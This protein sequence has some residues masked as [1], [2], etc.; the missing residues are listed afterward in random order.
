M[1][2]DKQLHGRITEFDIQRFTTLLK[3][4]ERRRE[5]DKLEEP[6]EEY[7]CNSCAENALL[8]Y[9][10]CKKLDWRACKKYVKAEEPIPDSAMFKEASQVTLATENIHLVK[11]VEALKKMIDEL[12]HQNELIKEANRRRQN[13]YSS[14]LTE[15]EGLEEVNKKLQEEVK[16]AEK[17]KLTAGNRATF[18][19]LEEHYVNVMN[20]L[21]TLESKINHL[22][23]VFYD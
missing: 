1:G 20:R 21:N 9:G 22:R 16:H 19:M 7:K 5:Q 2:K 17:G 18:N 14:L 10:A 8:P 3:E 23:V 6:K 15:C 13:A 11:E 12:R 4:V